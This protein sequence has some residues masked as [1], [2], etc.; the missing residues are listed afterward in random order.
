MPATVVAF[1]FTLLSTTVCPAAPART[2]SL[3]PGGKV[4]AVEID[5]DLRSPVHRGSR[6]VEF[7]TSLASIV[8]VPFAYVPP[9]TVMAP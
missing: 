8:N 5:Y 3:V 2:V 1:G 9:V 4:E 7:R 6:R